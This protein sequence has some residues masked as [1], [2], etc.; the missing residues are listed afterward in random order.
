[1]HPLRRFAA[2]ADKLVRDIAFSPV[3][4]QNRRIRAASVGPAQLLLKRTRMTRTAH[5]LD[6]WFDD[7]DVA[8]RLPDRTVVESVD[9]EVNA[10][11]AARWRRV[12]GAEGRR[13]IDPDV[14]IAQEE[15]RILERQFAGRRT[16]GTP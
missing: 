2:T 16:T 13:S 14:A 11:I 8:L 15:L 12:I 1:V 10:L 7:S 9:A 3:C 5:T 6:L 4:R